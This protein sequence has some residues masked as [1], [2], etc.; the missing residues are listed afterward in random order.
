MTRELVVGVVATLALGCGRLGFDPRPIGDGSLDDSGDGPPGDA[1]PPGAACMHAPVAGTTLYVSPTG[2]DTNPGTAASPVAT[3]TRAHALATDNTTIVVRAGSYTMEPGNE[4]SISKSNI[5]LLSEERY[6][7]RLPRVSCDNCKG[8]SVEQFE[9]TGSALT[10]MQ[11]S[12][13]LDVTI[14]DNIIHG[15]GQAAVRLAGNITGTV[16]DSNVIYDATNALVHVN[17]NSIVQIHDN[18][19]FESATGG[20]FPMIW[21]EGIVSSTFS[22]NV[23]FSGR[24]DTAQYGTLALG[25]VSNVV[26][27]NNLFGPHQAIANIDGA[28]GLDDATGNASIRFNT[29]RGPFNGVAFATSRKDGPM[30]STMFPITHNIFVSPTNTT[31][32]FSDSMLLA[33]ADGFVLQR[34][35]YWN[36]PTGA[37]TEGGGRLGPMTDTAR[38]VMDPR[39]VSAGGPVGPTW[40]PAT[41]TFS[42]GSTTSCELRLRLISELAFIPS[43][44][45]AAGAGLIAPP[46]TDIRGMPRPTAASLGAYEP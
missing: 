30:G 42:G 43:S 2:L 6:G 12:F 33:G 41:K 25:D 19:V 3:V 5:R 24:R 45:P 31:Q 32:P 39:I 21:L 8:L 29:F 16:V 17:D 37:F 26:I 40:M 13:G 11:V 9:I 44:S 7:A 4:I 20:T 1:P 23:V 28:I 14:R 36:P 46:S 35:L 15:C 38:L 18:V 27:E 34:N 10:C 22:G